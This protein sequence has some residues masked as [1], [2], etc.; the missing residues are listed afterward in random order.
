MT[1]VTD[2]VWYATM[3]KIKGNTPPDVNWMKASVGRY[4][5]EFVE[6]VSAYMQVILLLK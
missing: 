6:E 3:Q 4:S 5:D 2:C 1:K